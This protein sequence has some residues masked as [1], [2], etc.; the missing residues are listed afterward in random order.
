MLPLC[1]SDSEEIDEYAV[2]EVDDV[3]KP[4]ES[5]YGMFLH[6]VEFAFKYE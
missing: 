2:D 3:Y 4:H 5:E 1:T 6:V